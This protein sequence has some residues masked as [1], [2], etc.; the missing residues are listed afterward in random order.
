MLSSEAEERIGSLQ[1]EAF[2]QH[3]T[4]LLV[5]TIDQMDDYGGGGESIADFTRAW[6]DH[7]EIGV[8][9]ESGELVNRGILL[10]VS[11]GD[12]M[13][14]IEL[15]AEWGNRWD[16]HAA[17]IMENRI[18]SRFRRD[19][20]EGGILAGV[21]AL[22]EMAAL[23]PTSAP[24]RDLKNYLPKSFEEKPLATTPLPLWGIGAMCLVGI[25]LIVASFFFPQ[26]RKWM[27]ITGVGL[28][29]AA[30]VLWIV[31]LILA[32]FLR[33]KRGGGGGGG[34]FSGG[35]FGGGFSGG[36]GASGSW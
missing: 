24:P 2:E 22:G 14:R 19:D 4:P 10:L 25:A 34:G 27:L 31:L 26:H 21:E 7:W 11:R 32:I 18:I 20:Y 23:D 35:G 33:G 1:K 28:I 30:L 13:A 6:F 17:R 9:R 16:E 3:D 12:R 5:V 15:G 36:G 29:V 8:R